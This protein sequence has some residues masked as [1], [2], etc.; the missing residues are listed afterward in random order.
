MDIYDSD[1]PL[2]LVVED[3]LLVAMAIEDALAERGLQ[4]VVASTLEAADRV[5]TQRMP[6][7]ALLDLQLPDGLTLNLASVLHGAGCKVALCSG[8]D[9]GAVPESHSFALQFQKPTSPDLLADWVVT[10][11]A[12]PEETACSRSGTG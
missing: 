10:V 5:L 9:S 6:D 4:V 7:V 8:L 12:H 3:G 2:V 11:L 1:A